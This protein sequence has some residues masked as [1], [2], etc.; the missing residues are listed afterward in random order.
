MT[1]KL[2]AEKLLKHLGYA[3]DVIDQILSLF[4]VRKSKASKEHGAEDELFGEEDEDDA[5]NLELRSEAEILADILNK[6]TKKEEEIKLQKV[7]V[8]KQVV[9]K[10]ARLAAEKEKKLGSSSKDLLPFLNTSK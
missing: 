9:E 3:D 2:R 4:K 8:E 5:V 6:L 1:N 7:E 10:K